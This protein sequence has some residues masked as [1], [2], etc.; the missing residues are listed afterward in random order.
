[1]HATIIK[2]LLGK[3]KTAKNQ[4][5]FRASQGNWSEHTEV[6]L[7]IS[8]NNGVGRSIERTIGGAA[9][10]HISRAWVLGRGRLQ[11][12]T[13]VRKGGEGGKPSEADKK[14]QPMQSRSRR[15]FN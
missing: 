4:K 5:Q 1:V 15:T 12:P 9:K 10:V 7:D 8:K 2:I 11:R 6:G 14:K 3:E 13:G